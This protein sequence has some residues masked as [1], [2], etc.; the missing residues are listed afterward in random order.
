MSQKVQGVQKPFVVGIDRHSSRGFFYATDTS[1]FPD[2]PPSLDDRNS[3]DY[4]NQMIC[5]LLNASGIDC[6]FSSYAE[7]VLQYVRDKSCRAVMFHT[8]LEDL[9]DTTK[10][11]LTRRSEILLIFLYSPSQLTGPY[12]KIFES[13]GG[14]KMLKDG[15][16]ENDEKDLA[17]V[18]PNGIL[19]F[20][21]HLKVLFQDLLMKV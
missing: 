13:E 20:V 14:F 7:R 9:G 16:Y 21:D 3:N 18:K 10:V 17:V 15:L 6:V 5:K 11:I 19:P 8:R 2:S 1:R 4:A 12:E